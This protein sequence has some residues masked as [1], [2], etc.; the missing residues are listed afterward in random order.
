MRPGVFCCP[1]CAGKGG[2]DKGN[3]LTNG[4]YT[5]YLQMPDNSS[6]ITSTKVIEVRKRMYGFDLR[7]KSN[8]SID[9]IIF[10]AASINID[11]QFWTARN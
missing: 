8:I 3:F 2:D 4:N 5:L 7:G 6:P 11:I 10:F 1:A 9:G